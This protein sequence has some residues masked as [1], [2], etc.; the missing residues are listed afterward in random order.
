MKKL[1]LTCIMILLASQAFASPYLKSDPQPGD[2]TTGA[3]ETYVISEGSKADVNVPAIEFAL[4]YDLGPIDEGKHE[5]QVKACNLWGCSD[6]VPFVFIKASP[7]SP[8]NIRLSG[9]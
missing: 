4:R 6:P 8:I 1:F 3:V 2:E 5:Y 9:E 7:A